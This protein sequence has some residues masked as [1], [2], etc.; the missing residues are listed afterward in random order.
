MKCNDI[1]E[2][3]NE[4]SP[5]HLAQEWDN[6]GLLV[7]ERSAE[8]KKILVALDCINGVV[9]EAININADMIITHH[10]LI[11]KGIK[12]INSDT[13]IGKRILKLIKS[14]ISLYSAHTNLDIADGGTNDF[15][16]G[17]LGIKNTSVLY[18][19][20][21][22]KLKTIIVFVPKD[23]A[24]KVRLAMCE[25]G[26]GYIGNY[27]D[28]T[29]SSE[30][31]GT[32]TPRENTKP[33]IGE[34]FKTERVS[35]IRIE[36]IVKEKDVDRIISAMKKVHPYEEVAFDVY[37][38]C[39]KHNVYGLGRMG[40]LKEETLFSDFAVTVKEALGL[41]NM[42]VMGSLD[43]KIKKVALC[44]GSGM[45]FFDTALKKKADLYITADIKFHE[46]QR[47]LENDICV[48]D[49]T[50]YASENIIV[51]NIQKRLSE[52]FQ[53]VC[54]VSS[55]VDGQTFKVI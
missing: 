8:V 46:A 13:E 15:L 51:K 35:E 1:I 37:D 42:R 5:E 29:F 25:A 45:E 34:K 36:T 22:E 12:K 23:Y 18:E 19:T 24:E 52:K 16:C 9:D 27:S 55:E 39:V 38:V 26:A 32:F 31:V 50:H 11:F 44:T 54:V 48:I 47:I 41:S 33:F 17:I 7:G 10:P 6:V 2:F 40:E 21:S 20:G 43:K 53:E 14:G 49:A 3:M 28:C 30:G 4:I